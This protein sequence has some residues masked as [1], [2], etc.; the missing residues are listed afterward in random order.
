MFKLENI[1]N[2]IHKEHMAFKDNEH[3]LNGMQS[4]WLQDEEETSQL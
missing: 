3:D 1:N 2:D 4:Q